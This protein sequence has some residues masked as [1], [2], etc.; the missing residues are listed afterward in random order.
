MGVGIICSPAALWHLSGICYICGQAT[1]D[2]GHI[3]GL[4][5]SLCSTEPLKHEAYL[6]C[7]ARSHAYN[8]LTGP[9]FDAFAHC[10]CTCL[11]YVEH[12]FGDISIECVKIYLS[13]VSVICPSHSGCLMGIPILQDWIL[14]I[15]DTP[16]GSTR[17]PGSTPVIFCFANPDPPQ[18]S[19]GHRRGRSFVAG[20]TRLRSVCSQGAHAKSLPGS[21]FTL[22][23][24]S[25]SLI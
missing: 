2:K 25:L 1:H 24:N 11:K 14:M 17:L 6:F 13:S 4:V 23:P 3:A 20:F 21:L 5:V 7:T 16:L 18:P 19:S 15:P 9:Y 8:Y 10:L 12:A 22:T